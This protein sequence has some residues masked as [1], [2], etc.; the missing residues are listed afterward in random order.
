MD[1]P[2]GNSWLDTETKAAL[3]QMPPQKLAPATTETFSVVVLSCDAYG[4]HTRQVR[5]FDRVLR[6]SLVDAEFQ[7]RRKPPFVVKRELTVADAMLAQFELVCCDVVSV[8]IADAVLSRADPSYL[9]ELYGSLIHADEFDKVS[10]RL[11]SVPE[12]PEARAFVQQFIG[13]HAPALPYEMPAM[14]KKARIMIH[15]AKKI[16]AEVTPLP[17]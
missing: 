14:R 2:R 6:T 13:S 1:T 8:F 15:W 10:I 17:G 16:G 5:A 4:D 9:A 3:Q 7:T 12:H 11:V